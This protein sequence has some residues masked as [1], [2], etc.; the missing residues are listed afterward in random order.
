MGDIGGIFVNFHGL[1]FA[2][3]RVLYICVCGVVYLSAEGELV[4]FLSHFLCVVPQPKACDLTVIPQQLWRREGDLAADSRTGHILGQWLR[5][6]TRTWSHYS[7]IFLNDVQV[8]NRNSVISCISCSLYWNRSE[9]YMG[10]WKKG[11]ARSDI[12]KACKI[13]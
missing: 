10:Q 6:D 12:L 5:F 13:F 1:M 4:V 7:Q 8:I 2:L 3:S 9:C 11:L